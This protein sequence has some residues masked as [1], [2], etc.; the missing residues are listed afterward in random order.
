MAVT[1][2][3]ILFLLSL[4]KKKSAENEPCVEVENYLADDK[5]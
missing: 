3:V 4:D 5:K 2:G 1:F